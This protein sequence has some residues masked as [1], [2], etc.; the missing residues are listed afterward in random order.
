MQSFALPFLC[1]VGVGLLLAGAPA[2]LTAA[3]SSPRHLS[4]NVLSSESRAHRVG[5]QLSLSAAHPHRNGTRRSQHCN[6]SSSSVAVD[7]VQ[8]T[9]Q[10]HAHAHHDTLAS[11]TVQKL[12]SADA[13]TLSRVRTSFARLLEVLFA[14]GAIPAS[15]LCASES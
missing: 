13:R 9:H 15:V 3:F 10:D 6:A 11:I 12:R 1:G 7:A 2:S 14:G 8:G 5:R 4:D